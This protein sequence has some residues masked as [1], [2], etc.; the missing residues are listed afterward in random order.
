[1][2]GGV[3]SGASCCGYP[4]LCPPRT[5]CLFHRCD[6]RSHWRRFRDNPRR[7]VVRAGKGAQPYDPTA[8]SH[9]RW[10]RR[11][12]L[13]GLGSPMS[14][15]PQQFC[16]RQAAATDGTIVDRHGTKLISF[17]L[18]PSAAIRWLKTGLYAIDDMDLVN[19][20]S[21]PDVPRTR[22]SQAPLRSMRKRSPMPRAGAR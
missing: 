15:G 9:V 22:G 13:P 7:F 8:N 12:H 18:R 21:M 11:S 1:M 10:G 17:L 19:I 6:G 14:V 20:I 5:S 2:G 16:P 3:P 4:S